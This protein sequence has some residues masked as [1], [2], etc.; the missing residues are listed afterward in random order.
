[1]DLGQLY[2]YLMQQRELEEQKRREALAKMLN[3][4]TTRREEG[5]YAG[6]PHHQGDG[7]VYSDSMPFSIED[8]MLS[9]KPGMYK[10]FYNQQPVPATKEQSLKP[11]NPYQ[12]LVL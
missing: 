8:Y 9:H 4:R 7:G 2:V 1:M 5:P 3:S 11:K 6:H 12:G 10:F